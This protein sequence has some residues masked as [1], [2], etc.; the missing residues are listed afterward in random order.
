MKSAYLQRKN[1][2]KMLRRRHRGSDHHSDGPSGQQCPTVKPSCVQSEHDRRKGLQN[3]YSTKQL[4]VN[5]FLSCI[6]EQKYERERA[7]FHYQR[8]D[9]RHACFLM[10]CCIRSKVLAVDVAR[11]Q[12]R[13]RDGHYCG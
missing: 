7:E 5:R 3:P 13:R 8:G 11:E 2:G 12:V 6:L 9:F 10:R 1:R 4:E